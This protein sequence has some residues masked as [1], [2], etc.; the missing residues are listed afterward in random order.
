MALRRFLAYD[1]RLP[2]DQLSTRLNEYSLTQANRTQVPEYNLD[3]EPVELV[4]I[5]KGMGNTVRWPKKPKNP[6][7]KRETTKWCEF[8]SN[9]SHNTLDCIILQLEDVDLLKK[10]CLQD[11][12][13][14]KERNTLAIWDNQQPD[15]PI[16]QTL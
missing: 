15:Q 11:F 6:D 3:I 8:H 7:A 16:E 5:M 12:L 14:D 13:S 10:G 1:N 9:H 4:A 2:L